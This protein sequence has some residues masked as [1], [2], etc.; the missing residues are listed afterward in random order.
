MI[1]STGGSSYY[2]W[3]LIILIL[4]SSS[5][6]IG[7]STRTIACSPAGGSEGELILAYGSKSTTGRY[8]PLARG[9]NVWAW[10][11]C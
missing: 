9:V 6:S 2:G 1:I 4:G 5:S 11:R 3:W 10:W 7:G 8:I